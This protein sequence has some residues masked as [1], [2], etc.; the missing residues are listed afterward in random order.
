MFGSPDTLFEETP[1]PQLYFKFTLWIQYM[2]IFAFLADN[3][4][5]PDFNPDIMVKTSFS[6]T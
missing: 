5:I 3:V 1:D 4:K 2:L 6:C